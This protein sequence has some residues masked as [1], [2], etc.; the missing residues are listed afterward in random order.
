MREEFR[1]VK[2]HILGLY[3]WKAHINVKVLQIS[4]HIVR[5]T[6][7]I[8]IGRAL[9][10][11]EFGFSRIISTGNIHHHQAVF[12]RMPQQIH[13]LEVKVGF[14]IEAHYLSLAIHYPFHVVLL[15]E[16]IVFEE[17]LIEQHVLLELRDA[18]CGVIFHHL[19]PRFRL[20]CIL[21][22]H[23][24]HVSV[25]IGLKLRN[26]TEFVSHQGI[27]F[28]DEG[29]LVLVIDR[30]SPECRELIQ[31][32]VGLLL[33]VLGDCSQIHL[34][35]LHGLGRIVGERIETLCKGR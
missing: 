30:S 31:H 24:C 21:A 27:G 25:H 35:L 18:V 17:T 19:H 33:A 5:E 9:F 20:R 4:F 29:Q 28:L 26:G 13:A 2:C 11:H 3:F 12:D 34:H 10:G 1:I 16:N 32:V 14:L 8:P 23:V 6:G 7:A 15:V 22:R